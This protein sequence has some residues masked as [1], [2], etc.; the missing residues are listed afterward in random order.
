M[1]LPLPPTKRPLGAPRLMRKTVNEPAS[2]S[3]G[4]RRTTLRDAARSRFDAAGSASA[5][6]KSKFRGRSSM[7]GRLR[8][9]RGAGWVASPSSLMKKRPDAFGRSRGLFCSHVTAAE[10]GRDL[11]TEPLGALSVGL[12]WASSQPCP[13][14]TRLRERGSSLLYPWTVCSP[15][16]GIGF[17]DAQRSRNCLAGRSEA[18]ALIGRA[19]DFREAT[20]VDREQHSAAFDRFPSENEHTLAPAV[21]QWEKLFC[22]QLCLH[23]NR[24]RKTV[25]ELRC[26]QVVSKPSA[27][28]RNGFRPLP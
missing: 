28:V 25:Q 5:A 12:K 16:P 14:R 11:P 18:L 6:L 23:T 17:R 9:H 15:A 8:F 21:Q 26:P 24:K 3:G 20:E 10:G 19:K 4:R 13:E 1:Q 22:R 7:V 2:A 27:I